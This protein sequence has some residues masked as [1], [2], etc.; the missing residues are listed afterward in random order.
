M[1]WLFP[2]VLALIVA[3]GSAAIIVGGRLMKPPA[4]VVAFVFAITAVSWVAL[5]VVSIGLIMR[6]FVTVSL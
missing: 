5:I 2:G 3:L 6:S 4:S 1:M